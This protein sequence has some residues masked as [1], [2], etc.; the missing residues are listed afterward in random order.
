VPGCGDAR[1]PVDIQPDIVLAHHQRRAGMQPHTYPQWRAIRPG[2]TCQCALR[3]D[4]RG[5]CISGAGEGD[6]EAVTLGIDLDAAVRLDGRP[7]HLV[8][9]SARDGKA[10]GAQPPQQIGRAFDV[11]EEEGDGTGGQRNG[12]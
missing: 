3:V 1:R 12:R 10:V 4:G 7:Y 11:G 5:Q 6:E 9:R 8:V 2:I